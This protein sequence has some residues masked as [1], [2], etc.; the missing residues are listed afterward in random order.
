MAT[1]IDM[2]KSTFAVCG[3]ASARRIALERTMNWSRLLMLFAKL[4]PCT[5]VELGLTFW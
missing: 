3:V 5:V 4:P 2:A 1:G